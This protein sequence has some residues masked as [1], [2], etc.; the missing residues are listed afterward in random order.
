[1]RSSL[2]TVCAL[3]LC[4]GCE[5]GYANLGEPLDPL[6]PFSREATSFLRTSATGTELVIL[7]LPGGQRTGRIAYFTLA[8][9]GASSLQEGSYLLVGEELVT[10][11]A[12][13]YRRANETSRSPMSRTG[14]KVTQLQPLRLWDATVTL[15]VDDEELIVVDGT[16]TR[17]LTPLVEAIDTLAAQTPLNPQLLLRTCY[18]QIY[19]SQLRIP[20]FGGVGMTEY[21]NRTGEFVGIL[22][23]KQEVRMENL[24]SPDSSFTFTDYSDLPGWSLNGTFATSTDTAGDGSM[25]GSVTTELATSGAALEVTIE[26]GAVEL[27]GGTDSGGTYELTVGGEHFSVDYQALKDLDLRQLTP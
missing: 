4:A 6:V 11:F 22:G 1:V 25:S 19:S 15:G 3:L 10:S 13:D 21:Y 2:L 12:T 18:L 7:E 26:F 9:D 16:G 5:P 23:G 14:S 17:R 20:G 8:R 27:S 24:M